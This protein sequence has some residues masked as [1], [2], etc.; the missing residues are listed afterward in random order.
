MNYINLHNHSV[1]SALD[2]VATIQQLVD[3]AV[4]LNQPAIAITEHGNFN[5]M[6]H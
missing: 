3:K 1:S 2:S 6:Y 4:E 5:S